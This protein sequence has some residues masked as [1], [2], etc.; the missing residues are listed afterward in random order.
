MPIEHASVAD[1][2]VPQLVKAT[3][4]TK[5]ALLKGSE[6]L[7]LCLANTD[8]FNRCILS[9][10]DGGSIPSADKLKPRR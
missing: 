6:W 10:K 1:F 3:S 7:V 2:F 4:F 8:F 9:K 5:T